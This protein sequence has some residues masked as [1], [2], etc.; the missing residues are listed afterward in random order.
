MSTTEI[1]TSDATWVT[2]YSVVF[3]LLT[4]AWAFVPA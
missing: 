1:W 2:T 4:V 3:V